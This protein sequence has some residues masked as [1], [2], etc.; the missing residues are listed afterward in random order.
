MQSLRFRQSFG[1]FDVSACRAN[2]G[3][4]GEFFYELELVQE[5]WGGG[6]EFNDFFREKSFAWNA[7]RER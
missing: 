5:C 2:H 6:G 7:E 1:R 4:C 3:V